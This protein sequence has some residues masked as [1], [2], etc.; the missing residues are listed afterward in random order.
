MAE[1]NSDGNPY[2]EKG[3]SKIRKFF[4][5]EKTFLESIGIEESLANHILPL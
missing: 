2:L 4:E 5:L 3:L 1:E